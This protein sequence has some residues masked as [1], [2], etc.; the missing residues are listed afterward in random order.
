VREEGVWRLLGHGG[1]GGG[2]G[3]KLP[4]DVTNWNT[5]ANQRIFLSHA[6]PPSLSI[7]LS[8]AETHPRIVGVVHGVFWSCDWVHLRS[9]W[10]RSFNLGVFDEH[11]MEEN[12]DLFATRMHK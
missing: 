5:Q 7:A 1:V 4:V 6:Y 8:K 12:P 3:Q 2:D 10:I 11:V 9:A